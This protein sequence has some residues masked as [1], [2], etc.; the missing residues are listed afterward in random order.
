MFKAI[1]GVPWDE[2]E[3]VPTGSG[4]R[5][6]S[7]PPMPKLP[8]EVS[9]PAIIDLAKDDDKDGSV[10]EEDDPDGEGP[11][12]DGPELTEEV[13]DEP[14]MPAALPGSMRSKR[15]SADRAWSVLVESGVF[16]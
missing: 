10:V 8:M 3:A 12:Q 5:A 16:K 4:A 2:R 7:L 1:K 15:K 9:K 14:E 11:A 6:K 13:Y